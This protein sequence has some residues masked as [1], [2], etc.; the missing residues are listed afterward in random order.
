MEQII[1]KNGKLYYGKQ[2]CSDGND[3]Y[4]RFRD[5]YHASLGKR[6]YR[7]LNSPE[8]EE[9]IHG[10]HTYYTPEFERRLD[11]EFLRTVDEGNK[12]IRYYLL[13]IVQLSYCR[14]FSG[15]D[16]PDY[17]EERFWRWLDWFI[18]HAGELTTQVG[19][20]EKSGRTNKNKQKY[21]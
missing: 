14:M 3:A 4:C 13:G 19:R 12:R 9:R 6:V 15:A 2:I 21:R 11:E 10:F 7:R 5:D 1:R 18:L 8:R 16:F 20:N 17:E